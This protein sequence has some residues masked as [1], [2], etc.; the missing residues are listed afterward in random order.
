M[1][2]NSKE[3]SLYNLIQKVQKSQLSLE[4]KVP[5]Q[6][7]WILPWAVFTLQWAIDTHVKGKKK[8]NVETR[9]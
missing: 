7:A 6:W 4:F 2:Q 9:G 3:C 5:S 8:K 1:W